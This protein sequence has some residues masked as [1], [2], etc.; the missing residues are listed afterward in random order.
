MEELKAGITE[1]EK[2][3]PIELLI[4][5]KVPTKHCFFFIP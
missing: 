3:V 2:T 4:H 1:Y 5:L